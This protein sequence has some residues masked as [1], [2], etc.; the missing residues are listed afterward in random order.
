MRKVFVNPA[1]QRDNLGDSV[2]RRPYLQSLRPLGELHVLVGSDAD[3]ASGLGLLPSDHTY[4]SRRKWLL[5]ALRAAFAGRLCFAANAGEVVGSFSEATRSA[6]QPFL[7][8]AARARKGQVVLAGVSVR[9]GTSA[10]LTHLGILARLARVA[11]WRDEATRDEVGIGVVQPDWAFAID[12]SAT[13]ERTVPRTMLAIAM[14]GDRPFPADA[15]FDTVRS[16]AKRLD[17][18]ITVVEQVRRDAL[19]ASELAERLGA[20]VIVWPSDVDHRGQ[21]AVVREHYRG[22]RAV[23][24]DRIHAL[25]IGVT[26]GAVPIGEIGR[27]HV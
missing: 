1:G 22:C 10:R 13:I 11:T 15:W 26:E 18:E 14:R 16:L 20:R 7:A 21:E 17:L 19:R 5:S 9:P 4:A 8:L 27:A 24:S 2:L 12:R 23:I 25:I 3:Y 6:W